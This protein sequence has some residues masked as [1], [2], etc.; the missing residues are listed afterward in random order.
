MT[1][2]W[3][4]IVQEVQHDFQALVAYVTEAGARAQTTYIRQY[5]GL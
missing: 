3:D 2:N 1:S 5:Q 4:P